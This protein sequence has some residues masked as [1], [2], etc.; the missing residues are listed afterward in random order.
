MK[1][2]KKIENFWI[3]RGSFWI[4][5]TLPAPTG[6]GRPTSKDAEFDKL[7]FEYSE[8]FV[9]HCPP[10]GKRVWKLWNNFWSGI[11]KN[12]QE[13]SPPLFLELKS[14]PESLVKKLSRGSYRNFIFSRNCAY[15]WLICHWKSFC[16]Y[17]KLGHIWIC[18]FRNKLNTEIKYGLPWLR[19]MQNH[20]NEKLR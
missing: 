16:Q 10:N 2:F 8:H 13:I 5:R 9:P 17:F 15:I 7:S 18:F 3:L 14:L 11:F 20:W 12:I 1:I 19:N 6:S 4:F